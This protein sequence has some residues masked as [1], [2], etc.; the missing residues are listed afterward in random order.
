MDNKLKRYIIGKLLSAR[1]ILTIAV[2]T[3]FC[4]LMLNALDMV[5]IGQVGKE[6]FFGLFSGF[7]AIV[8]SIVTFYFTRQRNNDPK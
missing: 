6:F 4:L 2:T 1:F 8:G 3:T 5:A 7:S